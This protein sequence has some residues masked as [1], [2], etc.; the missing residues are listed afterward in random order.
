MVSGLV[1]ATRP[2]SE[3]ALTWSPLP[4]FGSDAVHGQLQFFRIRRS[5][6][7]VENVLCLTLGSSLP[8]KT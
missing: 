8:D 1:L 2:L 6:L 7:E 3:T 5:G 4:A